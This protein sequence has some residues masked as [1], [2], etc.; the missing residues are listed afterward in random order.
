M[1]FPVELVGAAVGLVSALLR[2]R[3]LKEL[4]AHDPISVVA[5]L[6]R[7]IAALRAL[8]GEME[9]RMAHAYSEIAMGIEDHDGRLSHGLERLHELAERVRTIAE[10]TARMSERIVALGAR[11]SSNDA[12]EID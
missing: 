7:E 6:T 2:G 12:S 9:A 5:E 11:R 8:I 3:A 1:A 4:P 10:Q